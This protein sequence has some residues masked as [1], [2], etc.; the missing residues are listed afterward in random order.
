LV[1]EALGGKVE[2]Y[3][4]TVHIYEGNELKRPQIVAFNQAVDEHFKSVISQAL[5]ILQEKDVVHY[6]LICRDTRFISRNPTDS[7]DGAFATS[8]L[9]DITIMPRLYNDKERFVP[10][11]MCGVLVH[12]AIHTTSGRYN[13]DDGGSEEVAYKHGEM[14]LRQV[15]APQWMIDETILT[16]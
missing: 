1:S 2:W 10:L 14:A 3:N 4:N 15:G 5:N 11:Y 7:S 12:E 13:N 8:G 16:H 9:R 6:S